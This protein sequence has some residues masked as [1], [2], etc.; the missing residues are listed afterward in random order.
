MDMIDH[1]PIAEIAAHAAY[2]RQL[3]TELERLTEAPELQEEAATAAALAA[4]PMTLG[5]VAS[6]AQASRSFSGHCWVILICFLWGSIRSPRTSP[7]C[8]C[9]TPPPGTGPPPSRRSRSPT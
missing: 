8:G 6:S 7:R 3:A 2:A 9:A 1:D 4:E 5:L